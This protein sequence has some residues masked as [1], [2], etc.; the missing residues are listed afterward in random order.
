[1][2]AVI[3]KEHGLPEKLELAMDWVEPSAGEHDVLIDVKAAGLNFPDVLMIQGKYQMQPEMPFIPGGECAG[4]VA[5]VG[6]KVSRFKVGDKVTGTVAKIASFGAFVSLDGDIDG[7]IH[8]SQL[9]EDHVEK[10]KD[11]IKVADEIEARVIKVDK[12]ERRSLDYAKIY[13]M[14]QAKARKP[15]TLPCATSNPAAIAAVWP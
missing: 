8:I 3:C 10:V 6:E 5:A 9:S 12:I 11:V 1:M 15:V 14:A 7:L 2:K 13:R 4:V